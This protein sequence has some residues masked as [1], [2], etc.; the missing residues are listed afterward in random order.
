M[1]QGFCNECGFDY[2]KR[3]NVESIP[4]IIKQICD[5]S[6][7][8][9]FNIAILDINHLPTFHSTIDIN[10][11]IIY[12]THF[13]TDTCHYIL[14]DNNHFSPIIDIKKFLNVRSFCCK[15]QKAFVNT[16]SFIDHECVVTHNQNEP[17]NSHSEDSDNW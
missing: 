5:A 15:C 14:L 4:I 6:N 11:S 2:T 1:A 3:V 7:I 12:Q 8:D 13:K 10:P 16:T 9:Y 17:D